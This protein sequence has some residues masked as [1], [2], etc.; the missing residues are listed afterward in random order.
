MLPNSLRD[1]YER[2]GDSFDTF[3]PGYVQEGAATAN[4][5]AVS[6]HFRDQCN[7]GSVTVTDRKSCE[8]AGCCWTVNDPFI[9]YLPTAN[10]PACWEY[11]AVATSPGG[12]PRVCYWSHGIGLIIM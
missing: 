8:D 6:L 3:T 10:Q 7:P 12:T 9:T 5:C 2:L 1:R 4:E 11:N